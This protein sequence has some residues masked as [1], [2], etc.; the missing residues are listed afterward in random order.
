MCVEDVKGLWGDLGDF[1]DLGDLGDLSDLG[2]CGWFVLVLGLAATFASAIDTVQLPRISS[3]PTN[4]SQILD[5]RLAS[6][7][8]EFSYMPTFGGNKTNPNLL[9]QALMQR[10]VEK[11]RRQRDSL[12]S[13]KGENVAMGKRGLSKPALKTLT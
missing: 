7:S 5:P 12:Y 10:L 1:G 6:F 11:Q 4:A 9:T 3:K 13:S 2:D 8:M